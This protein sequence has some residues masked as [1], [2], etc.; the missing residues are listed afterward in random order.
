MCVCVYVSPATLSLS[1]RRLQ[2]SRNYYSNC[3]II[4]GKHSDHLTIN[5]LLLMNMFCSPV[6][7]VSHQ[8]LFVT[9]FCCQSCTQRSC[10]PPVRNTTAVYHGQD[11]W[12]RTYGGRG[13][14]GWTRG[15]PSVRKSAPYL[16]LRGLQLPVNHVSRCA[17]A[18][19]IRAKAA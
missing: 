16:G 5:Q 7:V 3:P 19:Q 13:A 9:A 17:N 4:P 8:S 1:S 11:A 15:C 10:Q 12:S 18:S 14:P 6:P 2:A